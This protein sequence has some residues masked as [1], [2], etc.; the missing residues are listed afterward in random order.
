[1][2]VFQY[3]A[4][5]ADGSIRKGLAHGTTV[6]DA[7]TRL[8]AMGLEVQEI[9]SAASP[10]DPLNQASSSLGM[11]GIGEV[12]RAGAAQNPPPP[13]Q[14][15]VQ[16][17]PSAEWTAPSTERRSRLVTD[18]IGPI[19]GGVPLKDLHFFFRQLAT[20]LEAG[21]G[22]AQSLKTLSGQQTHPKLK[23]ILAECSEHVIA[24]RPLSAGLQRYPEVFSPL[25][26]SIVR[27]GEEGG[28]LG[29]QCELLADYLQR[30]L[31]LRTL[32]RRETAY[33]KIVL[34]SSIF[35]VL[36]ANL[37][38]A[39]LAPGRGGLWSPLTDPRVLVLLIPTLIGMWLAYKYLRKG[40]F[41]QNLFGGMVQGVPY[42]GPMVIGFA[43]AKFGRAF[44]ALYRAGVP[45]DRALLLAADACGN[46]NLRGRMYPAAALLNSGVSI[47][48]ALGSTRAFSPI[49]MDMLK[50]GEMTGNIEQMMVKM[51]EFYEDEGTV[52]ARQAAM[53]FGVLCFLAVAVYVLFVMLQVYG[54]YFSS[55]MKT[56]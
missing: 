1:M 36:G 50:T 15:A 25:I 41:S 30:D 53:V 27:T 44:G 55:I 45:F 8:A 2:P 5:D 26:L 21:V 39:A 9:S 54:G 43:M 48:E 19:A 22:M 12:S 49:V 46:E 14:Q 38:I 35:I 18:V 40:Q 23:A 51:A 32:I 16:E 47:S 56:A 33:P 34:A 28:F 20:M 31:E 42:F 29:S 7:A 11:T 17:V 4:V 37:V 24:G 13:T 10:H 3:R 52:R 6:A